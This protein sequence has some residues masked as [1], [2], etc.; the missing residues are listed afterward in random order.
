MHHPLPHYQVAL[1]AGALQLLCQQHDIGIKYLPGAAGQGHPAQA[2]KLT[3]QRA[4]FGIGQGQTVGPYFSHAAQ[5]V[6]TQHGIM[7]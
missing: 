5:A 1:D 2:G 4:Y 3:E 7:L 6:Y